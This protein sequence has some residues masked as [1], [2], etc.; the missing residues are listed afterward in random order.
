V[1]ALPTST[2][3]GTSGT[4]RRIVLPVLLLVATMWALEILDVLLRG[5]L[6]NFGIESRTTNG[7]F[8]ILL[9]PFLHGGFAH[10]IANTLPFLLLGLLVSWR[11]DGRIWLITI[12]IAVVGG[13][14]VWLFGPPAT[15]TIGAS[16]L[17]FGYLGYILAAGFLT[18]HWLD[19]VIAVVVLVVYGSALWGVLPFAV[20][21]NVSWLAHLTGFAAGVLAAFVFAKR[22]AHG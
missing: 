10:L 16:G 12:L 9:S 11:S 22:P 17:I 8:G 4:F 1:T 21:A 7:L 14:A 3:P 19:I 6:D 2:Q 15:V 20:A 18:R 13:L 5:A